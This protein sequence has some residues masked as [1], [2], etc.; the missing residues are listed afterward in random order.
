MGSL[1]KARE[2]WQTNC[3]VDEEFDKG[4]MCTGNVDND[5][6]G[7]AKIVAGSYSGMLRIFF[8]RAND[9]NVQDQLLE[10]SLGEPILQ[11]AIGRFNRNEEL[12]LAVLLP[13]R[14]SVYS[15]VAVGDTSSSADK[16]YYSMNLLYEHGFDRT[17][18]NF[19]HGPFGQAVQPGYQQQHWLHDI[20]VQSMDGCLHFFKQDV[21]SFH[22]F[23]PKF[24]LPG[25]LC[26]APLQQAFI[27]ASSH[28]LVCCYKHQ[29][30]A[31]SSEDRQADGPSAER[32]G[33]AVQA[34]W[35]ANI[36]EHVLDIKVARFHSTLAPT[37]T[38]VMVLG[39]HTLF[40][41]TDSGEIR[42][43]KRL[44]YIPGCLC[45]FPRSID[46]DGVTTDNLLV[47]SAM[48]PKISVYSDQKLEWICGLA[49]V[50]V[51]L[52]VCEFGGIQ[53]LMTTLDETGNL[54]VNY[55]GTDPPNNVVT[56]GDKTDLNYEEMDVEHRKLL[57]VIREATS[58][59]RTEPKDRV[60]LRA[61]MPTRLD[62]QPSQS[63][64]PESNG[65]DAWR[66]RVV[67]AKLIISYTG[68]DS[69]ENLQI[70]VAATAP[71]VVDQDLFTIESLGGGNRTPL[72]IPIQVRMCNDIL[73]SNMELPV[74]AT[75][76]T[77]SGEP[78]TAR[79][80]IQ[81]PLCLVCTIVAPV[82]NAGFKVTLDTNQPPPQLTSIFEDVVAQ[83]ALG[84]GIN[85]DS[86]VNVL[87]FQ[88][89]CGFD[90]TV[91]VSKSSNRYRLQSN[92]FHC[93]WLIM[94]VLSTRLIQYFQ[95]AGQDG[96]GFEVGFKDA[97]PL[98]DYFQVICETSPAICSYLIHCA[99]S[100]IKTR[101]PADH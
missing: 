93:I 24:L 58:D 76:L 15:V 51:C 65:D 38:D 21:A 49:A 94:A 10:Q 19:C 83:S 54:A 71:V 86:V 4:C 70:E 100:E 7:K 8:P 96:E 27:T 43:Q 84:A 17:A 34:T 22:R 45:P 89:Y 48:P 63:A 92:H 23:L 50:P 42:M 61:E 53:G 67:S 78:R 52:E 9:Y 79:W 13:R 44:E 28:M 57:T 25:S 97:L 32:V 64:D 40:C 12:A 2:W 46:R 68:T 62:T 56:T 90:V 37:Q 98:T 60:M 99:P 91:L 16:Q 81:L 35:E 36:G 74:I 39:E 14:L 85:P 88:Y 5:R 77:A 3:G 1:F 11:V 6:S 55:L 41:L 95:G 87:T 82:K 29:M 101:L 30:L 26:Y 73:P 59:M 66:S 75:Y 47:A 72:I 20:C 69:V 18:S 33:K 80:D 31:A